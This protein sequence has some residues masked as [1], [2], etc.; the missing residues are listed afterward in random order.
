MSPY[1]KVKL[2]LEIASEEMSTEKSCEARCCLSKEYR[3]KYARV[4][5]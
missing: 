2:S 1:T 3:R 5:E 4:F